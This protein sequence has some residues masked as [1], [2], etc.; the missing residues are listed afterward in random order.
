MAFFQRA[1]L[2]IEKKS[3]E[4]AV[5]LL[6]VAGRSVNVFN[7]EVFADLDAALD[8]LIDTPS[9]KLLGIRSASSSKPIA[10][11]DIVAFAN[12]KRAEEA[13]ALSELGQRLFE[14]LANLPMPTL[15]A[16]QGP[17]LG[18]GLEFALACDYRL[19]R[20]DRKTQLGFPEV[21]LGLIPGWAGTQRLPRRVGLERALR[22][23]LGGKR[24]GAREALRWGL[25]DGI[26]TSEPDYATALRRL[27]H[28]A[29]REGKRPASRLPLRTW[30][31]RLLESNPVGRSLLVRGSQRILRKRVPEDMPAPAEALEA[32]RIGVSQ[33]IEAGLAY[34]RQAIGR[35]ATTT[36][37]RNLV[38]LFLHNEEARKFP[39]REPAGSAPPI[40]RVGIVGAGV[41]GAGIAQLAALRGFDLVVQEVNEA[42][43]AAGIERIA[44]LLQKAAERQL[45]SSEEAQQKVAAIE[46]TTT[47][48]GFADV[49]LVVE[50]ASEALPL[51]QALFREMEQRTRSAAILATNT[52]SLLVRQ[53]QEGREHPERVAG[54]HFFN[55]V[56]KLPLVEVVRTPSTAE[57]TTTGLARWAVALG[58]TPVLVADSPGFVV[59]RILMPYLFEAL[60]LAA[61]AVPVELLDQT[62]RRFG[63]PMGPLELLDQVGLDVAGHVARALRPVFAERTGA[64]PG[65]DAL[66]QM[67]EQM[68]QQGWLGQKCGV[69]FYLYQGKKRKPHRAALKLLP[70]D[71]GSDRSQV[72]SKLPPAVQMREARERMVLAMVNEAAACLGERVAED[73]ESIDLAMVLGTGWAP[74][75]G[76][77]LHY[78]DDRGLDQVVRSL[79]QLAER[80][81]PRFEPCAELQSRA[82]AA[83]SFC[84]ALNLASEPSEPPG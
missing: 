75:R 20:D 74:H 16:I 50:A 31:Q 66:A 42:A 14:K 57:S 19:V 43:L 45:V 2:R 44:A 4:S 70:V 79:K 34:E 52:S 23:I 76:G 73:A 64:Y 40:R 46:R 18:G 5:L 26:A 27:G 77:P 25:A 83:G 33:G 9:V 61:Q 13:T 56:H 3:E 51:K 36:A 62:M 54:L 35:L 21:E 29:M 69:G 47:W 8:C 6:D 15:I 63:M 84:R 59:N 7:R 65:L 37:C 55:P 22:M 78:A 81:G 32:V 80:F 49:D 1:N 48:E 11:A 17:C 24:L 67:F 60:V 72:M 28:R 82:S 41:M 10:G 38:G 71:L 58:K 12:I 68:Q 39:E 30:R 53:L